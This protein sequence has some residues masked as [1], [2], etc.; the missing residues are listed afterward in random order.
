MIGNNIK[1]A[2]LAAGLTQKELAAKIDVPYQY[3]QRWEY[4]KHIPSTEYIFK[5]ATALNI[6][7]E[8]L[9]GD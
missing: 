7:A 3:I 4:N 8:K 5:L 6:S 9:A 2:R 1:A